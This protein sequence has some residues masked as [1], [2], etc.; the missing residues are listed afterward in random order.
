MTTHK[1]DTNQITSW[2]Q[3][4]NLFS[5]KFNF[6]D[7]YGKNMNAWIDCMEDFAID[8]LTIIEFGDCK[9]FKKSQPEIHSAIL[10]CSAFIN[11]RSTESGDKPNLII[12]M[13]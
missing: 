12:S 11:Y 8:G 13:G 2:K 4:H 1:I 9:V 5:T 3:F 6:P 7:Y 10:E